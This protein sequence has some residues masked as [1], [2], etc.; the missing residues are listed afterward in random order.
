[1]YALKEVATENVLYLKMDNGWIGGRRQ[2]GCGEGL[3]I[4]RSLSI[5]IVV[6]EPWMNHS[7]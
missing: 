5:F 1:M 7:F 3:G 2:R 6:T 4:F